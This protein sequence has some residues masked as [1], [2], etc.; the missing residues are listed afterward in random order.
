MNF[1]P[2][3][4]CADSLLYLCQEGNPWRGIWFP[5]EKLFLPPLSRY[6]PEGIFEPPAAGFFS[7][8]PPFYLPP[9]PLE[10]CFQGWGGEWGCTKFGSHWVFFAKGIFC[11]DCGVSSVWSGEVLFVN[12]GEVCEL[13]QALNSC[14]CT[15]S[16]QEHGKEAHCWQDTQGRRCCAYVIFFGQNSAQ[17]SYHRSQNSYKKTL[18]INNF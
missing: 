2:S 5:G 14:S 17:K 18:Y 12:Q 4:V 15:Q 11:A 13:H 3:Q 7:P 9:P 6:W 10:G 16:S 1:R 8:P